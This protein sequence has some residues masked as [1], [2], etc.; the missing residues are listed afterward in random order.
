M[1][2]V[3]ECFAKNEDIKFEKGDGKQDKNK[4]IQNTTD[5]K[6]KSERSPNMFKKKRGDGYI[7]PHILEEQRKEQEAN[8]PQYSMATASMMAA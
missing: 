6:L 4:K 3:C 1:G 7:A 8:E 2:A 5:K